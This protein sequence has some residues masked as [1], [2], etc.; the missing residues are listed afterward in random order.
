[1]KVKFK[2]RRHDSSG[3]YI[4]GDCEAESWSA[5]ERWAEENGWV[6]VKQMG[7]EDAVRE[8]EAPVQAGIR[9]AEE[10]G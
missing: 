6:L 10:A 5:V 8:Q 4:E 3:A 9:F 1:M 7:E 2:V